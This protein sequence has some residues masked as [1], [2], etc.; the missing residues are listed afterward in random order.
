MSY[1][2]D[3]FIV[4]QLE[5]LKIPVSSFF[6]HERDDWHPEKK[7]DENGKL[8]L[9]CGCGQEIVGVVDGDM[10]NI[11]SISMSGEG[12]GTFV[13]WIL[14]S[15]LKHSTGKLVASCVWEGGDSIKKL[16][17]NNGKVEWEEIDI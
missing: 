6:I 2:I 8:T 17:V 13:N 12:S 1:N 4:K 16:T 14:E 7:I 9:L 3:T 15:A 5:D 11:E 10:I